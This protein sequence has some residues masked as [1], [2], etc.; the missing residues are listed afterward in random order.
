MTGH[1]NLN[2]GGTQPLSNDHLR[3]IA[4]SIF[5]ERPWHEMSTKYAF[6]PTIQVVDRLRSEGFQP[7][8]AL[9][10]TSR[11]PGKGDFTKHMIRF[12]DARGSSS[13]SFAAAGGDLLVPEVLVINAHDGM[14]AYHC[15]SGIFRFICENGLV[16]CDGESSQMSV[17]HAGNTDGVIDVTYELVEDFPRIL[18]AVDEWSQLRLAPP[19]Q[20]AFAAAA[21]EL[22]YDE[23]KAPVSAEQIL[24]PRREADKTPTLWNTYNVVQE[25]LVDGGQRGRNTTSHRRQRTRPVNGISESTKLNKALWRLAEEMKKLAC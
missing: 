16:V 19:Q 13:R 6:I 8:A 4:P 21:L 7:F 9:Q 12:R 15:M 10:S 14:S 2:H 20:K 1:Q 22:R 18:N 3:A 25:H 11:I 17:R 5:A 23:G 24:T